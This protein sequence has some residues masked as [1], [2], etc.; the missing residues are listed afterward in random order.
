MIANL[1]SIQ[2]LKS[3]AIGR[4]RTNLAFPR[5]SKLS[6]KQSYTRVL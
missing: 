6:M 1:P 2:W 5:V 3:Q 4:R